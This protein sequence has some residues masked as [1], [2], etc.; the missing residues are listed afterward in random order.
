MTHRIPALRGWLRRTL[1]VAQ[2]GAGLL[3]AT[4]ALAVVPTTAQPQEHIFGAA[5]VAKAAAAPEEMVS[6]LIVKP[7]A[8]AGRR[9]DAAL[10]AHDASQLAR[11]AHTELTVARAM[12]GHQHVLRLAH[13]V[14][15]SEARVIAERLMQQSSVEL[16][17]PDRVIKPAFT[18]LDPDY[19]TRQW[20]YMAPG[21]GNTGGANLPPAWDLT[22][23]SGNVTVAVLDTGYRQHVD[24]APVLPGYDFLNTSSVFNVAGGG[25]VT[26]PNG[27]GDGRDADPT[28]PGDWVSAGECGPGEPAENSSWHGTFVAGTVAALVNNGKGGTGVAPN[29]RILPVRVLGKC[30]GLTSDIVDGMRWAAGL[31]AIPGVGLNPNVANVLN[32]SL[33]APGDAGC[34]NTFQSAV[35]DV[36]AAGKVIV[37]AA[38]NDGST[39]VSS[40]ANCNGVIAVTAHAI[41]GDN[42]SYANI[43]PQITLSAPGGGCGASA[44]GC[45]DFISPNG[46]GVYS[47]SNSGATAPGSDSYAVM[48]GTSMAVPHVSGVVALMLSLNPSLTPAQITAILRA[49][50]RP[51]PA[52]STCT[53]AA[54]QGLCGAGL[55]DAYAALTMT[56]PVINLVQPSQIVPPASFVTLAA[57]ATGS[58]G[59]SVVSWSWTPS[60]SNPGPVALTGANTSTAY[61]TAPP[62]GIYSFTLTVVDDAGK[63]GTA[64]AIVRVNSAPVLTSEAGQSVAAGGSLKFQVA[65]SD[66][67]GD[68]PIFHAVSLPP[69]ATLAADGTFT[70]SSASPVGTYSVVYYARDN[71]TASAA[72]TVTVNVTGSSGGGGGSLD[73][74]TLAALLGLALALRIRRRLEAR[75]ARTSLAR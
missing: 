45:T 22:L 18:P 28:D 51:H 36:V 61:F 72:G 43:G 52:G 73:L 55:L 38:G 26:V 14:T 8:R 50:A 25:T 63:T 41:D 64:V 6:S 54:Y 3:L 48:M 30:G 17:E 69:G 19:A 35:N 4:N 62:V 39:T 70:W 65:A 71:Y 74:P 60:P 10:K 20:H 47:L 34:S 49:S 57:T 24:L 46:P 68:H 40:P 66:S 16:A 5:Q 9:L 56:S 21:A 59:H 7:R 15:L 33:A 44:S 75:R 13:P 58:P 11:A 29:V 42:A 32:M 37:A 27:D 12:S 53:L 31:Y 67:D 1:C 23:G 2:A